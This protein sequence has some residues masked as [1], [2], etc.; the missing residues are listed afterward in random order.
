MNTTVSCNGINH[1]DEGKETTCRKCGRAVVRR[2]DGK[3]WDVRHYYTEAGNQRTAYS[4]WWPQH[5]CKQADIEAHTEAVA[6]DI[7]A[8]KLVPQQR[9]IVARGRKVAK[10]RTGVITW[11]G[12]GEYGT[13]ARVQPDDDTEAFF[14]DAKNLDVT[15]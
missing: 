1:R 6:R 7:A 15:A 10:G 5:D 3:R 12:E 13:R 9:V 14:I 2:K 11:V 8:G 4:C